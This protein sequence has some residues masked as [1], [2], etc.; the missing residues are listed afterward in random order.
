MNIETILRDYLANKITFEEINANM[1]LV[2]DFLEDKYYMCVRNNLMNQWVSN[3]DFKLIF[4]SDLKCDDIIQKKS[5]FYDNVYEIMSKS[6]LYIDEPNN[7]Y[8]K[9]FDFCLEYIPSYLLSSETSIIIAEELYP[10]I[11]KFNTKKDLK[12]Y[13][14]ETCM[15]LFH[16]SN[17]NIP[18]WVQESEWPVRNG[19]PCKYIKRHRDGDKVVFE[20]LDKTNNE[21]V[22]IQQFY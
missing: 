19:K 17:N 1:S 11:S 6:G 12:L 15:R 3:K 16:L 7:E 5:T 18:H 4:S 21:S 20:F 9:I 8:S 10:H 22:L 2:I 14:K 13:I